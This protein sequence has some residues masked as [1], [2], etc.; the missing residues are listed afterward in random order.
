MAVNREQFP[1]PDQMWFDPANPEPLHE[2]LR[3]DYARVYAAASR[4]PS[5]RRHIEGCETCASISAATAAA[6]PPLSSR[7]RIKLILTAEMMHRLLQLPAHFE[8]VHM[9]ADNDPNLVSILVAGEGL[10]EVPPNT[11]APIVRLS[12]VTQDPT[13]RPS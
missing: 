6:P 7:K 13:N 2:A 8:V 9:F 12:D 11:E 5:L 3:L 4:R 1:L 10:P